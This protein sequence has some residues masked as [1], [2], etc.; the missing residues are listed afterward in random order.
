[1]R[2]IVRLVRE[3]RGCESDPDLYE[4]QQALLREL[5]AIEEHRAGCSQ[6]VKRLKR[7]ESVPLDAVNP[8]VPVTRSA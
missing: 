8:A 1:M 7:G 6:V 3:L 2:T 4:F 5:L